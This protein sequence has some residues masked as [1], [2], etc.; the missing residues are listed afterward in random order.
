[1]KL[2]DIY[3]G[4]PLVVNVA[5][6]AA[7]DWTFIERL[8]TG[9]PVNW[10]YFSASP[11]NSLERH[12]QRPKI[13]RYRACWQAT[14]VLPRVARACDLV[15]SHLPRTTH[16]QSQ[17][18]NA[19]GRRQRHLAFSFN[20]TELPQ[21]RTRAQMARS[22][23]RVER[24]VVYSEFERALYAQHFQ[25]PIERFQMLHWAM[26]TPVPDPAFQPPWPTY[27]SAAGGEGRDYRTLLQA[28]ERLPHLHLV[29]VTRPHALASLSVPPNVHVFYNLPNAQFWSVVQGSRALIVPLRDDATPCGHITLVGAMKL[30]RP[31]VSTFSHGTTDYVHPDRNALVSPAHDAAALAEAVLRLDGDQALRERLGTAGRDFAQ[32]QCSPQVWADFIRRQV[33][34]CPAGASS[35]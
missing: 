22:L 14:R 25:L 27:Y 4:L 24:F 7:P 34:E 6:I 32:A 5:E 35:S 17:F 8:Y 28:F 16:W 26:D 31:L 11:R 9:G 19:M 18:M 2:K 20:F 13:G 12:V 29:I 10:R 23:Q 15:I 3:K 1:M 33:E 30:G 21:G